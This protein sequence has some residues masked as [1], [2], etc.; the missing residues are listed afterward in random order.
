MDVDG[1]INNY[2][3]NCWVLE[4]YR[5]AGFKSVNNRLI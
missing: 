1:G 5:T 2:C 4:V 3:H